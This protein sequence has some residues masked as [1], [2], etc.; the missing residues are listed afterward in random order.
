MADG[1]ITTKLYK[2]NNSIG[3]LEFTCACL[4]GAATLAAT[5]AKDSAGN[6]ISFR[7][8]IVTAIE[9]V[10]GDPGP[11]NGVA[12]LTLTTATGCDIC[13]G[14]LANVSA[15]VGKIIPP[16]INSVNWDTPIWGTLTLTL[17]SNAVN[18]ANFK[19]RVYF[20]TAI[21]F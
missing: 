13:G 10:P 19:V 7:G 14:D 18:G 12:D 16:K 8:D 3:V 17:A 6:N 2:S 5:P 4:A 20:I 15:T 9:Y 1:T 21:A 11:T